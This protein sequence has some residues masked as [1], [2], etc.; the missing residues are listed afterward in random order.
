MEVEEE[1]EEGGCGPVDGSPAALI[2]GRH[3]RSSQGGVN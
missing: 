3:K 2:P 1:V